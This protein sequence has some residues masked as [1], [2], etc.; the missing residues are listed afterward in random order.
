MDQVTLSFVAPE[1]SGNGILRPRSPA[2]TQ[3]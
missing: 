1:Y 3:H 2:C